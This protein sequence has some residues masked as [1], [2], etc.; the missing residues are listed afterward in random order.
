MDGMGVDPRLLALQV[1]VLASK[2]HGPAH[3][4]FAIPPLLCCLSFDHLGRIRKP[5]T[6]IPCIRAS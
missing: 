4:S 6:A 1:P 3:R 5:R 2:P